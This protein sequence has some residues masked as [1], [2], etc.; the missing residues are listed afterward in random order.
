MYHG[1]YINLDSNATRRSVLE[2][3]LAEQA[4]GAV[5][6]HCCCRWPARSQINTPPSLIPAIWAYGSAIT[7]CSRPA[8]RAMRHWHVVEDD[9]VFCRNALNQFD[10]LLRTADAKLGDWDLI[11]TDIHV[12]TSDIG[13]FAMLAAKMHHCQQ[14]RGYTLLDLE[15]IPFA[16]TSSFFINRRSIDKYAGLLADNWSLGVPIDLY[17]R[18]LCKRES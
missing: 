1:F 9:A 3:H 16:C 6:A 18:D 14:N 11:F 7:R 8:T 4:D 5:P 2:H 10:D 13:M 12:N 17:L 15:Q